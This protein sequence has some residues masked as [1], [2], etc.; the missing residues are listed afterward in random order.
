M[1]RVLVIDDERG[2]REGLARALKAATPTPY[3]VATAEGL[4]EARALFAAKQE[5]DCVLLDVRLKDGDG[6]AFLRE[7]QA[8]LAPGCP[9]IMATAYGDSERTIEAMKLGA[10][11]Y[12]TKPFD[13]DALL[14][15][16][17]RAVRQRA[18]ERGESAMGAVAAAP[19][20]AH[21]NKRT[22]VGSSAAMLSVWKSIGRAAA[23]DAPV[24]ITGETG[25]GKE[26]V[27][28]AIH[29]HSARSKAPFVA[30]NLAALT[31]TLLEAELFGY[32]KGAFTGAN[33]RKSGRLE[34]AAQGTLFLDEIGD[35]DL[36]LQTRLLRVLNDRR[37]ERVGGGS[38]PL[39]FSARVIAATHKPVRPGDSG[40]TLR[41]DLYYRLAVIEI[42]LPPLRERKSDIALLVASALSRTQ[43]KA[44][45]EEAMTLLASYPWPG[46]VRELVHSIERAAAMC[47]GEVIDGHDLP[48]AIRNTSASTKPATAQHTA[49][50]ADATPYD[51]MPLRD[52][53]SA[54]EKRLIER[55]LD[56]AK[57]NRAEAARILGIART[58]LYAKLEEHGLGK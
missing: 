5:F 20:T 26:L 29:E 48:E 13:L 6:L 9:V 15:T 55:A 49:T 37:F 47:G 33:T 22:L 30:V 11:D 12:V 40:A 18:L 25:T 44:V 27:A 4:A 28:R 36:S 45:S 42:A 14:A 19:E 2:V 10:F 17:Q 51:E 54:L 53:L 21:E 39:D 41:E 52:A 34:L 35:L 7:L 43:A 8:R 50:S 24:L 57:G 3:E 32:E 1:T 38:D 31:P 46:N 58:Q 56:K 16:V 23:S